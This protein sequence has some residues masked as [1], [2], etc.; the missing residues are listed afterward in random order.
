MGAIANAV[1][2]ARQAQCLTAQWLAELDE[3]DLIELSA[4]AVER[5]ASAH[6]IARE[7]GFQHS[8][9]QWTAHFKGQCVCPKGESQ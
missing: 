7:F 1:V 6:N 9:S 8:R 2:A 4:Y 5:P 3:D